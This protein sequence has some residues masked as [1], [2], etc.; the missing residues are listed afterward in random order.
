MGDV[1]AASNASTPAALGRRRRLL[2]T[3][4]RASPGSLRRIGVKVATRRL[5][6]PD[7]YILSYP[8]SGRTWLRFMVDSLLVEEQ[9][10]DVPHVFAA[11]WSGRNR[12]AIEWTHDQAAMKAG[13][14]AWA[15]GAETGQYQ[16]RRGVL[17]VRGVL[18]T[19]NSAYF[20]VTERLQTFDGT[21]AEFMRSPELGATK[22]AAFYMKC[23]RL[24]Q[25]SADL[26]VVRYEELAADPAAVLT[27]V[28][29]HLDLPHSEATIAG[30]VADGAFENMRSLAVTEAYQGTVIAPTGGRPGS[31]KVRSGP[32]QS[33]ASIF[34]D[35][36]LAYASAVFEP[37]RS[38]EFADLTAG[39]SG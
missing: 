22:L 10:L 30:A 32:E 37:L 33:S 4:V 2:R 19:L 7:R 18:P 17:L 16:G 21:P 5:G 6:A 34:D 39:L 11:E 9:Q 23:A 1:M 38:T 27:H 25:S 14:P 8:K 20:Q 36:D 26:V 15:L 28:A 24:R 35:D 12:Y 29:A 13:L 31:A 3:V